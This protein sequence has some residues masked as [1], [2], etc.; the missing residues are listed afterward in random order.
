MAE[1]KKDNP[2]ITFIVPAYNVEKFIGQCL[3]SL[4]H[5]TVMN[6]RIIIVNDGSKDRTEEICLEYKN[7]YNDLITYL[8]QENRGLGAA[9]NHALEYVDTSYV[10]F[11]DSDDWINS[12]YVERFTDRIN[13]IKDAPDIIF[14]LPWVYDSVTRRIAQ[15]KDK[16][17]YSDVFHVIGQY[18]G[19]ITN[20]VCDPRL[21]GLEVNACRKIYNTDLIKKLDFR[22][23]E[24][25]KW[26]DVPGHFE[27]L[28]N[29]DRC[30]AAPDIGF[31][32]RTNQEN[33]ITSGTGKSRLDMIP[34]FNKLLEVSSKYSFSKTERAYVIRLIVNFSRWTVNVTDT[35]YISVILGKLHVLFNWF[36][37]EDL[38]EYLN[39][40]SQ[41]KDYEAGW[42][43]AI[44]NKEFLKMA[45]YRTREDVIRQY[46]QMFKHMNKIKGIERNPDRI[47]R[48]IWCI[49][50]H[51]I[52]YTAKLLIKKAVRKLKN[53]SS[54][55]I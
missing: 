7:T 40:V 3:G 34:I 21:Y 45:D 1:N 51:G 24:G 15:W 14:T 39:T 38:I 47:E 17:L 19:T 42:V 31:Y 29:A 33:Q 12:K 55:R 36:E 9:R 46:N 52:R 11:L 23:P 30:I 43:A 4:V 41:N 5:Q 22:F 44:V 8:Y 26:E 35:E 10:T 20:Y 28:H 2:L 48:G 13:N 27:L 6:H 32:Y 18:S 37:E 16:D 25:L 53:I 49:K 54:M 50:D